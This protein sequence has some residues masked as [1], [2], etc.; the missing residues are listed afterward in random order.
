MHD[1][2]VAERLDNQVCR[3]SRVFP[4]REGNHD[5]LFLVILCSILHEGEGF[6][7]E[8]GQ[9]MLI[10]LDELLYFFVERIV[11]NDTGQF[12]DFFADCFCV[13]RLEQGSGEGY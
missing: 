7:L 6:V 11:I 2:R 9:P 1:A 4:S 8:I 12:L 5:V 3:D 13:R 10:S